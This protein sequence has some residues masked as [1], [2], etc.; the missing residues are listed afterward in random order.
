V[1]SHHHDGDDLR[2]IGEFKS[3][4]DVHTRNAKKA[5]ATREEVTEASFI[6]TALRAGAAVT[7]GALAL[8]RFDKA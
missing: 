2:A 1:V 7:H 3:R 6:A 5:G 4:P 8:K